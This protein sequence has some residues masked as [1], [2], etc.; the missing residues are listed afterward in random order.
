MPRHDARD[1]CAE[2]KASL[3]PRGA[4]HL[5]FAKL[6]TGSGAATV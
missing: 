4:A 3:D 2:T 1:A 6:V 5:R